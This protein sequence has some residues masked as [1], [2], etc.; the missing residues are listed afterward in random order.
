MIDFDATRTGSAFELV[1][2]CDLIIGTSNRVVNEKI[3]RSF[4]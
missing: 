4:G 2:I 3:N 1:V